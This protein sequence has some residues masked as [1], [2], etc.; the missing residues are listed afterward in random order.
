MIYPNVTKL[1]LNKMLSDV[2][3]SLKSVMWVGE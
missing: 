3:R 2:V 1:L